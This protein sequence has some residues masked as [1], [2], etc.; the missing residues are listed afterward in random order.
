MKD[1]C[2]PEAFGVLEFVLWCAKFSD[3]SKR[4]IQVDDNT[5]HPI[6]LSPLVFWKM[7]R[8]L[9]PNKELKLPEVDDFVTNY[10]GPKILLPYFVDSLFGLKLNSFQSD[11]DILKEMFREFSWLFAR[12]T[13]QK[14][15]AYFP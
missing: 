2:M 5:H 4:T 6:S 11:I 7:L 14:S 13:D 9:E 1:G 15:M 12:V 8:L 3:A 10:G